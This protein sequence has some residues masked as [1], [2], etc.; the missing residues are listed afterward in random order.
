MKDGAAK[1]ISLAEKVQELYSRKEE[2]KEGW[3]LEF[4]SAKGGLPK[5]LWES[6]SAFANTDGG[7]IIL[8]VTDDG[9][10]EGVKKPQQRI[11]EFIDTANNPS[12]CNLN[13]C[14]SNESIAV[15]SLADKEVVVFQIPRADCSD[16]P[17]TVNNISYIRYGESD[18]R[19]TAR[20]LD[21]LNSERL[22]VIRDDYSED[23]AIV[24]G[25]TIDDVDRETLRLY[26]NELRNYQPFDPWASQNDDEFLKAINAYRDD[27]KE[28]KSGLTLA[29]LLMFGT[30]QALDR[31]KPSL[32]LDYQ[33]YGDNPTIESGWIDRVTNDMTWSCNLYRFYSVVFPKLKVGIKTPFVL[34]PDMRR[35]D[36]RPA[37]LAIKEALANSL[38][39]AAYRGECSI[40]ITKH[41]SGLMFENTGSLLLRRELILKG[42]WSRCRNKRIQNLFRLIGVVDKAG[43]GVGKIM[44][45]WLDECICPPTVTTER[46]PDIVRW[47]LPYFGLA[48]K[49][50]VCQ[51][52]ASL[53]ED[54]RKNLDTD[55]I[56]VLSIL[57][58]KRASSH[59]EIKQLYPRHS[60]DISKTLSKLK[61]LGVISAKGNKRAS[62]YF[63]SKEYQSKIIK[64]SLNNGGNSLDNGGNSLD[65]GGNS[66]DNGENSLDNGGNSLD[67]GENSL[68]NGGNSLDN[69]GNSLDNGGNSLDNGRNSLEKSQLQTRDE[70]LAVFDN[71]LKILIEKT[72]AKSRWD[73]ESI[74]QL[75]PQICRG[76][77]FT[78]HQLSVLLNRNKEYIRNRY[79]QYLVA[80]GKLQKRCKEDND[81][82][83]AYTAIDD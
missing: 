49:D 31:W 10:I 33:E 4:K 16:R 12:K 80:L 76:R 1:T 26:R 2:W 71:D 37:H 69:G 8:G 24:D 21:K 36:K 78:L 77:Y 83:Q 19:C 81:P 67:N 35:A 22:I 3:E 13:L 30:A 56:I 59:S 61:R 23:D 38:I 58:A 62:V 75:I 15:V 17:V 27:T 64:I 34:N 52:I 46:N 66:L 42:G 18:K 11:K 74:L 28:R 39:H 7:L 29:G 54:Q 9:I 79:I 65:N 57:L 82:K 72:S 5:D 41:P 6:Y 40:K 51:L 25:S 47:I 53:S 43:T 70:L 63:I 48:S 14:S 45:G 44:H 55:D 68:D 60:A 73:L 20:D 50:E 32:Q